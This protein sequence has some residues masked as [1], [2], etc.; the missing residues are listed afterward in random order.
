[1]TSKIIVNKTLEKKI[2][3]GDSE[4]KISWAENQNKKQKYCIEMDKKNWKN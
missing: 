2:E 4:N 3:A 1:M